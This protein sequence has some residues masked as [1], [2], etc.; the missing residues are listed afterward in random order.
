MSSADEVLPVE[1]SES[2]HP[3]PTAW[4]ATF[5]SIVSAFVLGDFQPQLLRVDPVPEHTAQHIGSYIADYGETLV[6]LTPETWETSVSMWMDEHRWEVLV[7]L[8]T[9][10]E[11]RS[12]LVLHAYVVHNGDNHQVE[13]YMVYVP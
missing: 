11:G 1:D 8:R 7:D 10:S 2:A 4:R 13:I 6:E 3:V 5:E 12:D 9:E